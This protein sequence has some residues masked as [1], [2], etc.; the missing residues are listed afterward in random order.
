MMIRLVSILILLI[1]SFTCVIAQVTERGYVREYNGRQEKKPLAMVEI[2][3]AN[4]GTTTSLED[5][6][7]LLQFRTQKAGDRVSLTRLYKEGYELFNKTSVQQWN[8]SNSGRPFELLMCSSK[9][10]KEIY[11]S[12]ARVSY[13][14]YAKQ[15]REDER[16]VKNEREAGIL[17]ENEYIKK[18]TLLR[19]E[20]NKKLDN[21][22]NYIDRFARIDLTGLTEKEADI[23]ETLQKGDIDSAIKLYDE[24]ELEEQLLNCSQKIS[25]TSSAIARLEKNRKASIEERDSLYQLF[26]RSL[27]V[28]R[29]VG[30][31]EN[32]SKIGT[33]MK[34]VANQDTTFTLAV[35]AY[36]NYA[37]EQQLYAECEQYAKIAERAYKKRKSDS[38]LYVYE[39]L[40]DVENGKVNYTKALEYY[41]K[42][43]GLVNRAR[44]N[45]I[46][47]DSVIV[48]GNI[49]NTY[50]NKGSYKKANEMYQMTLNS[51][52]HMAQKDSVRYYF[53]YE[54]AENNYALFLR[55]LGFYSEAD[56]IWT[57][58]SA[59]L[60]AKYERDSVRYRDLL[61]TVET[62]LSLLR[63]GQGK[64]KDV[65]VMLK[66]L[67]D[68][69]QS[70]F[71]KA[72]V[73]SGA[74]LF[75]IRNALIEYYYHT[76]EKEKLYDIVEGLEREFNEVKGYR[77]DVFM[78]KLLLT[79]QH[80]GS[81]LIAM[82]E[83]QSGLNYLQKS[84]DGAYKYSNEN[85][86]LFCDL[87]VKVLNSLGI[88]CS[89]MRRL[90]LA[91]TFYLRA[92][93]E[94]KE[95]KMNSSEDLYIEIFFSYLYLG[96]LYYRQ[97]KYD[98]S[99]Q[100]LKQFFQYA[101]NVPNAREEYG[102]QFLIALENMMDISYRNENTKDALSYLGVLIYFAEKENNANKLSMYC[103]S[104][105]QLL[106]KMKDKKKA[107]KMWEKAEKASP[108]Y[109]SSHGVE[110]YKLLFKKNGKK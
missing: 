10:F 1:C 60:K 85:P 50:S 102:S 15:Q 82:K 29:I 36:A 35:L 76:K 59:H 25:S 68:E 32:F 8:I 98:L 103:L 38:L 69:A 2:K 58:L 51:A 31:M 94:A 27:D 13:E 88:A 44:N 34:S 74:E 22:D 28:L 80:M 86:I 93:D 52:Y 55:D 12:Y 100:Y 63:L 62:N 40:A 43:L 21:I 16:K 89:N 39:L 83:Y 3:V 95:I 107:R 75:M 56:S 23:L 106:Y 26:L 64:Y 96:N 57:E 6:S 91:E 84:L 45:G 79:Y 101:K 47:I 17:K 49:A 78:H 108:E 19:D 33:R 66:R 73:K 37:S 77:P 105:S 30:G 65:E 90:D 104:A 4:A 99:E 5:G 92:I 24:L 110:H 67:L 41:H 81:V 7:F 87:K 9:R 71:G 48:L 61:T 11:D 54:S 109:I 42:E 53:I 46:D 72:P 14:S 97:S 18:I 20:Y 70:L